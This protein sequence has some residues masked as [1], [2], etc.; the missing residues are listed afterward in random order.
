MIGKFSLFKNFVEKKITDKEIKFSEDFG[1]SLLK[2]KGENSLNIMPEELSSGE[3]HLVILASKIIFYDNLESSNSILKVVLIDEPE[4]SLHIFW[5]EDL[6]LD[7]LTL[8]KT[9]NAQ[10]I[11]ATHSPTII[12]AAPELE[13][14]LDS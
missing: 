4:I 9:E 3:Q 14:S 8:A 7:L 5:Q 6:L 11:V 12:A 1:F 10:L 13:Y 2:R